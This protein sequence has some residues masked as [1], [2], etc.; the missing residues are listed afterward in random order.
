M[1]R[2]QFVPPYLVERLQP[3]SLVARDR[4]LR[5]ARE[6]GPRPVPR[7][8]VAQEAWVVHDCGNTANLPGRRVRASGEPAENDAA[9]DVAVDEA[10]YAVDAAL[11]LCQL[12]GRR[13]FDDRGAQV[14][15]SVHYEQGYANA[16]WDGAQLVFGDGDGEVF[17]RFTGPVDVLG[18][19]FAHALVERT[20]GFT[21]WGQPGA[22]NESFA[23][24]FGACLK[25]RV[26]GQTV[27]EA[28][29]IVGEGLFLPGV[30]ARGLR[31]MA[32]PGTAYDD[33]RLGRDPQVGHLRDYV[34]TSEDNGGVH[35]NSGIPNRAFHL[36]ATAIG[37][38]VWEGAGRIWW[39]A[40]TTA[41][42]AAE[43]DFA[44]FAAAT[45][46]AAGPHERAVATAW[47][48]VGVTPM[49]GSAD[50]PSHSAAGRDP[51]PSPIVFVRRTGGL[52]GMISEGSVNLETRDERVPELQ[53][54]VE[55]VDVAAVGERA[56]APA[57]DRFVYDFDLCGASCQVGEQD[58]TQELRR[59]ADLLL[60]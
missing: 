33:P 58:L 46:I 48:Q 7:S 54:L 20:T 13:S 22:L 6:A 31:D 52:A 32:A 4:E 59:I 60:R 27:D 1:S 37:G 41:D 40:L 14:S 28:D 2:C 42:L 34:D 17:G 10:A 45:I 56:P 50:Q 38:S 43:S 9:V 19:E 51:A 25:Q 24:V 12:F 5:A 8:A 47:D 35:Y 30:G 11:A 21:Y 36:V 55:R 3:P 15:V 49:A 26:L 23:D 44:A 53:A 39:E 57:P 16:F 29:W 18:H